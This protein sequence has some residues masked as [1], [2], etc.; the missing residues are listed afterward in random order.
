MG[1]ADRRVTARTA[2]LAGLVAWGAGAAFVAA[3]ELP[4]REFTYREGFEGESPKVELWAKNGESVVNFLGLSEDRAC[5]GKRSLKL[6]VTLNSGSYHYWGVAVRTP[7]AGKLRLSAR[8]LVAEGT[9]AQVGF[10]TNLVFPPTHHSGCGAIETYSKPTG[11]WKT[12]E[13]DLVASGRQSAAGVIGNYAPTACGDDVGAA[14]D[15]WAIFVYGGQGQRAVVYLD[16]VRIEGEVPSQDDFNA[17]VGRRWAKGQQRFQERLQAWRAD[18]AAGEDA[19]A[20]IEDLPAPAQDILASVRAT[21]SHAKEQVDQLVQRGYG[22]RVEVDSLEAALA[23][24]RCA[25]ETIRAVVRGQAAGQPYLI[26]TPKAVTNNRLSTE[27]FP[28][29]APLGKELACSGCRGEYEPVCAAVYALEDV[30]GLSVSASDLKGTAGTIPADAVDIRAVKCWYQAG[31]EIWD[32]KHK[33]L[34]PELL[35][36]DDDLVRVDV[37][38]QENYLRSTAADGTQTYLLCS[39]ATSEDLNG[40]RPIDAATLQ[41]VNVPARSLKQFWITVHIPGDAKAGTYRGAVTFRTA[42]GVGEIPLVVTVHPF[43]L[44]NPRLLYSIYY[45]ATLSGDG[46]PTDSSDLKSEEQYRAEMADLKAH[47]VR[48]PANYQG[49]D[50]RLLPRMLQ[51]RKEVG[52]PGGPFFNLGRGTGTATSPGDIEALQQDIKRWIDLCRPFGYDSIYFYGADEATGEQLRAQQTAWRAVQAAGGKTFVA[53]YEKTFEAMGGL[54]NC[55]VLAG[56][57]NPDEAKKWHG[58]GSLAFCYAYP[59]VGNEEPETYRRHFGLELWKAGFDGAMDYAYQHGF[60][61][62]WND[63]DDKTY[64][65][66]NFSYPTANGVVDTIQWEGFREGVDDVRYVGTL[67]DIVEQAKAA[68]AK[69]QLAEEAEKWLNGIDPSGDLDGLRTAIVDWILRLKT[70]A[71]ESVCGGPEE[72]GLLVPGRFLHIPGPCP[73]LLPGA[74]GTWDD[75]VIEAA[76]ALHDGSTYYFF[77]HGTGQGKGYRLGVA[78][79]SAPLGPFRKHGD[80]PILDLGPP[81]SW[82]DHSVACAMV[83]RESPDRCWMW[84]SGSGSGP[85]S[86]GKWSIGLASA[87]HPLGPW[88]KHKGNPILEDFGYVGGVVRVDGKYWLYTAHPI[89]STGPDYSPMALAQAD[90]PVG[91][92]VRWPQNPVLREGD[93]GTWDHGGF[94]EAEVFWAE[95]A[96]HMFYGGAELQPER[97]RTRESIGYAV[98]RDGYRFWKH[99]QNPVAARGACP[100]A[101]AFA[102]VHAIHEPPFVYLYHTLRYLE[103]RIPADA[104][105][106]PMIENLGIQVL[107]TARPFRLK[108]PLVHG[109]SL[110]PGATASLADALPLALRGVESLSLTARC[111]YG[112]KAGEGL[113][114]HLWTSSDG[115][116]WT[117]GPEPLEIE[118]ASGQAVDC[119]LPV[120][121][122]WPFLKVL[123]ENPDPAERVSDVEVIANLGG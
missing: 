11:E 101:A 89:G 120:P 43:D 51:I 55:A 37:Q 92:W 10:G 102:E 5:E 34:V 36:K 57:P 77:Y 72:C 27:V 38:K 24:L 40:V 48:Y 29:P 26:Y 113:R 96:F 54:L 93:A 13:C 87:P 17:E 7:C 112:A 109:E 45:R 116:A 20:K 56:K 91:P 71:P 75:G 67:L 58:V 119:E 62:V 9:T 97:I 33:Q 32:T 104:K 110:A 15:R 6:D 84:Y 30:K 21:A 94:S 118:L 121:I 79:A 105:R 59:Q 103:P 41:P 99:P 12:V 31:R 2:V 123:V 82:D 90:S 4:L 64:R 42:R 114:L 88:E 44:A 53:C 14:L 49:M 81:G 16:D 74:P 107:V 19:L 47:G 46:K 28:I 117:E 65:D 66:H 70:A 98:S 68:P 78:T 73:I 18:L 22:S 52:L 106:F 60:G 50:D 122:N 83:L 85:G 80:R 1:N 23:A 108:M 111:R 25:P 86:R 39:G 115:K 61:H 3:A 100:N 95:G 8:V 63:F 35:L 69:R 76:D